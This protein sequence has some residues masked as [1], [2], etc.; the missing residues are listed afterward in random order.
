[1]LDVTLAQLAQVG[2]ERL[3]IPEV[4]ELAG[5]NKT[6]VYRRW[7][8]KTDL[9][10]EALSVAM[11]HARDAPDTGDLRADLLALARTVGDFVQSP[12]GMGVLRVLFAE[13]G[14][15][16]VRALATSAYQSQ[17]KHIPRAA[18]MRAV[19]R[20]ELRDPADVPQVLFSIAGSIMHR[21]LVEQ[22]EVTPDFLERVVDLV[23]H[24]ALSTPRRER[25]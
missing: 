13:G 19:E 20:G 22:G 21:V 5:V 12:A 8:T 25:R 2:F 24:G 6:S 11:E 16:E 14:N 4:A 1:V 18:L 15:P 3:S 23:L 10:R 9:V 7:P 17:E